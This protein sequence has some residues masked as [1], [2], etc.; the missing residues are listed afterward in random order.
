MKLLAGAA[1]LLAIGAGLG[2]YFALRGTSYLPVSEAQQS[3]ILEQ[4]KNEGVIQAY[5]VRR[6]NRFGW[7]YRVIGAGIRFHTPDL[8]YYCGGE[9]AG[10]CFSPAHPMLYLEYR[11]PAAAQA[12]AIQRIALT[13]M[14]K[15]R[16]KVFEVTTLG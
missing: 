6:F 15:A 4:A 10:P 14:P 13:H 11:P 1:L 2:T 16:I 7:D 12:Y 8:A 3:L 5:R 9:D